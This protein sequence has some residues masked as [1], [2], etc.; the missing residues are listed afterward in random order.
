MRRMSRHRHP[1]I[2]PAR[3]RGLALPAWIAPTAKVAA[4]AVLAA[5]AVGGPWALWRAGIAQRTLERVETAFVDFTGTVGLVVDE[6][7]VE[8]RVE[9]KARDVLAALNVRRGMPVLAVDPRAAKQRLEQIP[10]V[11]EATVERRLPG[12]VSVR[13]VERV[14]MALWQHEGRFVLIDRHGVQIETEEVGRFGDLPHIVGENAG[15]A[16]GELLRMLAAEPALERR[17]VAAIRVAGRRWNLRLD[18]GI[19]V[20]LPA[21]NAAAAWMQLAAYDREQ[22]ILARDIKAID[23]RLPD[24]V[25]LKPNPGAVPP[26]AQPGRPAQKKA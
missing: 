20:M 21:E 12:L 18:N 1:A 11:R 9:T 6:V 4:V 17:V 19:D 10:W 3:R 14:P 25:V 24:R 13:L 23:L 26:A 5:L 22:G 7:L 15:E 8:G 2:R 16:A